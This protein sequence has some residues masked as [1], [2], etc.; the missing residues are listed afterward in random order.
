MTLAVDWFDLVLAVL[1]PFL[2]WRVLA[3][4]DLFRAIVLFIVFGLLLA[5]VWV[6]LQALDVAL[7]EA[8]IG[9]GLTGALFLSALGRLQRAAHSQAAASQTVT[10][11]VPTHQIAELVS[12]SSVAGTGLTLV[13]T[14]VAIALG[15][16]VLSLP[17]HESGLTEQVQSALPQ[18]GV[19][20]PVTA[21]LLNFRGYDT[22]LEIGVLLLAVCGV[23]SLGRVHVERSDL[24]P[25]ATSPVLQVFVQFFAPVM[26]LV[27]GYLLWIGASAP[28]GAFQGGAVI[29]ALAVILLLSRKDITLEQRSSWLRMTLVL[30]FVVFLA[31]ALGVIGIGNRFLEYPTTWAG[32]LILVIETALTVSIATILAVLF[33]SSLPPYASAESTPSV[34]EQ[35][36]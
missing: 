12:P 19:T 17:T 28:G 18:S 20:N 22:L 5:L 11:T 6:R 15:W 24:Q 7:A 25:T 10:T 13:C 16:A 33:A 30:G 4:E 32:S 31:V 23:W 29:A 2:A 1:V 14:A 27:G 8:A 9:A 34:Q 26:I 36:E 35:H 3:T 21:V